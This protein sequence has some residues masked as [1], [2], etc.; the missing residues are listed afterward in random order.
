VKGSKKV[1]VMVQSSNAISHSYKIFSAISLDGQILSPLYLCL[2]EPKGVFPKA[3]KVYEVFL[4]ENS[5]LFKAKNIVREAHKS[6]IMTKK[7]WAS[8]LENVL[9]PNIPAKSLGL[10]DQWTTYNDRETIAKAKPAGYEFDLHQMPPRTTS[11]IQPLDV[12]FFRPYKSFLRRIEDCVLLD[13]Y[14][15]KLHDRD[16][17]IKLQS[18]FHNQ[19]SAPRFA[20]MIR[21]AWYKAGYIDQKPNEKFPTPLEF[22]FN[23]L[24]DTCM[25]ADC[26]N[27]PFIKCAHC[28]FD[29]CF[30]CFFVD[31]HF[32]KS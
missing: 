10:A 16:S 8:F 21:Y 19:F 25:K 3:K 26:S 14:D 4:K 12:Y 30:N 32:C 6:A 24:S 22:C 31:H 15:V 2:Q 5:Q 13:E 27:M 18:L 20:P 28:E 9:F 17:I 11:K 7:H 1:E 29:L 23:D